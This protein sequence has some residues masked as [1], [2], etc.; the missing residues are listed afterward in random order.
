MVMFEPTHLLISRT[1][2]T[3]VQ[4]VQSSKGFLLLTESEW[5]QN[6]L[7]AFE[8]RSK[9]GFFCRG[10]QVVGYSLQPLETQVAV[11]TS[12]PVALTV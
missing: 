12:A 9:R 6:C 10:I 3:P 5:R 7:P 11:T 2:Q 1:K 4:L 8:M